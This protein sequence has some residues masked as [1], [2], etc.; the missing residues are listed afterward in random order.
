MK[1]YLVWFF[2]YCINLVTLNTVLIVTSE[3]IPNRCGTLAVFYLSVYLFIIQYR[4][5]VEEIFLEE[6]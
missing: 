3:S 6:H 5:V 1:C 2:K 4:I